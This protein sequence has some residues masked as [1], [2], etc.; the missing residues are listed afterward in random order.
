MQ[1]S[2]PKSWLGHIIPLITVLIALAMLLLT[3]FWAYKGYN[4]PFLGALIEPNNVVSQ[5]NG[6]GWVAREMGVEWSDRLISIN[7]E[8]V[9]TAQE[10]QRLLAENGFSPVDVTF[11]KRNG[12]EFALEITPMQPSL[13]D[14]LTLFLVPYLVGVIFLAAGLWAYKIRPDLRASRAFLTF[15]AALS[16]MTVTFLDMNT[17]H[18]VVLLWT[19]SLSLAGGA[20]INLA[21]LFPQEMPIVTRYTWSRYI[22]SLAV[23]IIGLPAAYEIISPTTPYAYI[24]RWIVSYG[25]IAFSIILFIATLIIRMIRSLSAIVRQQSRIILF[26]AALAFLPALL[27]YLLPIASGTIPEFRPSLYFTPM[28]FFP[29]SVTYAIIRYRLLDVDQI[30]SRALTYLLTTFAAFGIFYGLLSLISTLVQNAL[31]PNDPLVVAAYLLLLMVGLSPLR[32]FIQRAINRLFYRSPADYRRVLTSLSSK[33]L[34]TPDLSQT[35][36]TLE[37]ELNKALSPAQFIIYLYNDKEQEYLP[38]A[39]QENS[40]PPY[41]MEDPLVGLLLDAPAPIWLPPSGKF[42]AT[43]SGGTYAH[44]AGYTFVPLRYKNKL[45]GFLSLGARRSGELYS[46]DDLDFLA[47]VAAQSTLALENARLFSNLQRNL[48]QTLEMKNLMDDI[49]ASIATGVI[50][51]DIEQKITLFNK[52]AEEI[53]GLPLDKVLGKSLQDALPEFYPQLAYPAQKVL[54]EGMPSITAEVS[55]HLKARGDIHLRLS[56]SP[57]RDAYLAT[58]GTT[59]FFE[60]LTENRRLE[61]EQERIH[62]TFGR[63]VAPR[64]RDRLLADPGNLRLD[65]AEET[66]TILFADVSGFT[67]FSE[68]KSAK[69]VFEL[70]N[71]YLD[72]AAQAILE[73]EGTLDKFIGDAVMAMWNSPDPQE[74]HA[75]RAVRAAQKMSERIAEAHLKLSDPAKHLS[76]HTGIATGIA[77]I[78]NVGTRELFNYT[79]IGDTVNTAQRIETLAEPGQTLIN[80]AAYDLV[81]EY[82]IADELAP[83]K[84][85]GRKEHLNLY[86][87]RGLKS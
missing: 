71:N 84:V 54:G 24:D 35:L 2:L 66:V 8:N 29:I 11:E 86:N 20:L 49:F 79:A 34:I 31:Q 10:R 5:I 68:R 50:T 19:L 46:G 17:T 59:I 56:C 6:K 52:A 26:G 75:L 43:I 58:K 81:A 47:A 27:L 23:L 9:K 57:L 13:G 77:M 45:I 78:G 12:E 87:L 36:K 41:K 33:L 60:D 72:L 40:A 1:K 37:E 16:I 22:P 70:L 63:V 74:D 30:L 83:A 51:T 82:I 4:E 55:P 48:D 25:L 18:H 53:L 42:P 76:F 38:H 15:A 7:G 73:E 61:A 64:V 14:F 80:K 62:T 39:S 3:P 85:K 21:L 67:A 65:G 44:L 32:N 28:V 69:D